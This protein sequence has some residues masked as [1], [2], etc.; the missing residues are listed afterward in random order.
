MFPTGK[1]CGQFSQL[2]TTR[3]RPLLTNLLE[4]FCLI[5]IYAN[6]LRKLASDTPTHQLKN[7]AL[8][9][10]GICPRRQFLFSS[11]GEVTPGGQTGQHCHLITNPG[12]SHR[13]H[14][15]IFPGRKWVKCMTGIGK[16]IVLC[17]HAS[18]ISISEIWNFYSLYLCQLIYKEL[19]IIMSKI[20]R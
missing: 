19:E 3:Y 18:I 15:N 12:Q 7:A 4:S 16:T 14:R 2:E 10:F 8:R 1:L 5:S 9:R 13:A 17:N 6:K 20:N 11:G